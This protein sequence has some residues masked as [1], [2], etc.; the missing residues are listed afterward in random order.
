MQPLMVIQSV[1]AELLIMTLMVLYTHYR[2]SLSVCV[3]ST[4]WKRP[5]PPSAPRYVS[6]STA[7]VKM[8]GMS[9][10]TPLQSISRCVE[11]RKSQLG[12]LRKLWSGEDTG[13]LQDGITTEKYVLPVSRSAV[14]KDIQCLIG[15]EPEGVV[16]DAE[17]VSSTSQ[18]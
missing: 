10:V 5:S 15:T 13:E 17:D 12:T 18:I 2:C 9:P 8:H 16:L 4:D 14:L 3:M 1:F 11:R 7:G 6:A